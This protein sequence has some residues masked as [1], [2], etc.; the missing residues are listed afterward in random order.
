[1][2]LDPRGLH[3]TVNPSV[4][5]PLYS[6]YFERLERELTLMIADRHTYTRELPLAIIVS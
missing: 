3:P 2:R 5:G 1:M 6:I 4:P